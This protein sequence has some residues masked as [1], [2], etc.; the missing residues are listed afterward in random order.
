MTK[1]AG[2]VAYIAGGA[3][4]VGE[5]IVRAFLE[6]GATVIT[7]SRKRGKLDQLRSLLSDTATDKLVTLTADLGDI[8]STEHLRDQIIDQFGH[9][10]TVV[11]SIGGTWNRG[12]P[13]TEV[14]MDE[15]QQYLFTNLTTH[16]VTARAFLPVL[17]NT[18]GSSYIF[19]GGGAAKTPIPNYSVVS[20]PAAGQLMMA[21]VVMQ[22]MADS[23]VRVTQAIAN[24]LV[25]T[26]ASRER[27][28]PD[29]LTADEIGHYIAWLASDEGAITN[30]TVPLLQKTINP[31]PP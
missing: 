15:W 20:I 27:A 10:D 21:Q 17:A 2:K 12:V 8:A 9:L 7:S 11:A 31:S 26:R 6:A 16:F 4:N 29:W 5:G 3:G 25:N 22:E 13:L 30:G 1:L 19:M 14:S 23:G 18:D 28:K 24:S